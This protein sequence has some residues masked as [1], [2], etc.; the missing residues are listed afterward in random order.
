MNLYRLTGQSV[1][2]Y[3]CAIPSDRL[4]FGSAPTSKVS[5]LASSHSLS[6]D[7]LEMTV[8]RLGAHPPV[9]EMT[10]EKKPINKISFFSAFLFIF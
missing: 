8:L 10:V 9:S 5:C 6:A 7:L 3:F 1:F 4:C 2:F